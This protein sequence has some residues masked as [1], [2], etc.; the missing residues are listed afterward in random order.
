M[1]EKNVMKNKIEGK[2][3]DAK[4]TNTKPITETKMDV[5]ISEIAKN[6]MIKKKGKYSD[7]K[8]YTYY[9]VNPEIS[10]EIEKLKTNEEK[11]KLLLEIRKFYPEYST[12][13][14]KLK[15]D[16]IGFKDPST[17]GSCVSGQVL[18]RTIFGSDY[19][20]LPYVKFNGD[21]HRTVDFTLAKTYAEQG[22][23]AAKIEIDRRNK[24]IAAKKAKEEEEKRN[25]QIES[26][27]K[28]L[29]KVYS[30]EVLEIPGLVEF[31][32]E[33]ADSNMSTVTLAVDSKEGV[34]AYV[35]DHHWWSGSSGI[36][37]ASVVGIF[38][39]GK[40][41]EE[42]YTYRDQ[43]SASRDNYA[44]SFH[45][46]E[47]LGITNT[48]VKVK[49]IPGKGYSPKEFTYKIA[50][51]KT[52]AKTTKPGLTEKEKAEFKA[53]V[54]KAMD[55]CID[56]HRHNHPDYRETRIDQSKID[57]TGGIAAWVLFEQIDK[58]AWT[59]N[60]YRYSLWT[61]KKDGEP[62]RVYEDH[63]YVR[64]DVPSG[65]EWKGRFCEIR[66]PVISDNK[67]KVTAPDGKVLEFGIE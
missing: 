51:A 67:V 43:Y 19:Q 22:E 25:A 3:T 50:K 53:E 21:R 2:E 30:K 20:S 45:K 9:Q 57:Y 48:S 6:F 55:E 61:M 31:L 23:K 14:G 42:S 15:E 65:S 33:K 66:N 59:G 5:A 58:C 32:C 41:V 16:H 52:N 10:K 8:E 34:A 1:N 27:K 29:A 62:K 38:R 12:C 63:A 37:M 46:I 44:Y 56:G 64:E 36:G 54:D 17:C 4:I 18:F 7:G 26:R 28:E 35:L 47:I 39:D 60:Q 40:N 13:G 11:T 49:A 24:E